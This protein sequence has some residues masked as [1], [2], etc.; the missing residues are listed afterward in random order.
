MIHKLIPVLLGM[1]LIAQ[2]QSVASETNTDREH[3]RIDFTVNDV[4]QWTVSAPEQSTDDLLKV[5][6]ALW[7]LVSTDGQVKRLLVDAPPTIHVTEESATLREA[8][9]GKHVLIKCPKAVKEGD[10]YYRVV[11]TANL[12]DTHTPR[13]IRKETRIVWYRA[14][15]KPLTRKEIR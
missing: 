12:V 3:A 14:K 2:A 10:R 6:P 7:H 5:I 13:V 9:D 11:V 8:S 4:T 15:A 1:I